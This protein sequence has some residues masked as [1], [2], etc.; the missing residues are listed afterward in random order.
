[1]LLL[2]Y[3][4]PC[5]VYRQLYYEQVGF[6]RSQREVDDKALSVSRLVGLPPWQL[7]LLATAKGLVA[8]DLSLTTTDGQV[9]DCRSK[10]GG[11]CRPVVGL[12]PVI[13]TAITSPIPI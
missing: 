4:R 13:T 8:G 12:G 3:G 6:L 9:L 10:P 5:A 1:M 2:I 11:E 7:G